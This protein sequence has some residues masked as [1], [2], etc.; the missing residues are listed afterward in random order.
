MEDFFPVSLLLPAM[1]FDFSTGYSKPYRVVSLEK[2]VGFRA[3]IDSLKA[4]FDWTILS[5][6]NGFTESAFSPT[7]FI[8]R[9]VLLSSAGLNITVLYEGHLRL[10]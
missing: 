10:S 4:E 7:F 6:K 5:R 9:I 3:S 1:S 8:S 2:F